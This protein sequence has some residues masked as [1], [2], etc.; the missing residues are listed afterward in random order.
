MHMWGSHL[1][2]LVDLVC[3]MISYL[4]MLSVYLIC[5][6]IERDKRERIE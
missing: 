2:T 6:D 5:I 3:H 4:I 1:N